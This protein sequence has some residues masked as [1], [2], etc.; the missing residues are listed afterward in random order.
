MGITVVYSSGDN[1]VGGNSGLCL[2][3]DGTQSASG[4]IFNPSF[5]STCPYVTSVGATQ[6][7]SGKTVAD[8]ESACEIVIRSGGGFSNYFGLP[9]YQKDAVTSYLKNYPPSYPSNLWNS[10][11]RSRAYPDLSANGANYVVAVDGN[12]SLVY[13]TSAAAPVV[14]AMLAMVND[15]RIE[16]GKSTLGFINPLI[17]STKF[18]AGFHDIT[19]GTN[20]GCGTPGFSTSRGWDPVTGLGTPNFP[21]LLGLWR[22]MP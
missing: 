15:A 22:A 10:T 18:A 12:F 5:P 14:G 19:N 20:P 4:K 2:N 9:E 8:P 1:G 17:Y 6:V 13:G 16:Q 3:P 7:V 11:G 21:V